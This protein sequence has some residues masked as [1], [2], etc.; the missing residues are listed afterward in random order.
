MRTV[1]KIELDATVVDLNI[2]A[3]GHFV[4]PKRVKRHATFTISL[5]GQDDDAILEAIFIGKRGKP[6]TVRKVMRDDSNLSLEQAK[7]LV[8]AIYDGHY[9]IADHER[10]RCQSCLTGELNVEEHWEN[11]ILEKF[12][13]SV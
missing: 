10:P 4:P 8:Q 3:D 13:P 9:E 7:D 5:A 6:L 2:G 12:V 11:V 1:A